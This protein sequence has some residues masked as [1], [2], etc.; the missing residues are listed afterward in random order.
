VTITVFSRRAHPI[1]PSVGR[2]GLGSSSRPFRWASTSSA[3]PYDVPLAL[4]LLKVPT[5]ALTAIAGILLLGGG[6]VPG[7]S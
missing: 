2:I 7:L 1:D 4:A 5:G 3:A 6:F